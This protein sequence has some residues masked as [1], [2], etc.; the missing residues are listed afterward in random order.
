M[1][2]PWELRK[3]SQS[4]LRATGWHN[5]I[6]LRSVAATLFAIADFRI[7]TWILQLAEAYDKST[8]P[9]FLRRQRDRARSR[10]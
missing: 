1:S 2:R 7:H 3:L 4:D 10:S 6:S 8:Q 5:E 9:T